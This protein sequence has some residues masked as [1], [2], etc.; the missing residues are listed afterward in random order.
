MIISC[1]H[2]L[3]IPVLP[4]IVLVRLLRHPV[5]PTVS[6]GGVI[7]DSLALELE[8]EIGIQRKYQGI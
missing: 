6:K 5:S 8:T 1:A 2:L 7:L 3:L 4:D